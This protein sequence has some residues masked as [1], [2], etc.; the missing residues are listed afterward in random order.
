M[1]C[2]FMLRLGMRK[3]QLVVIRIY[4]VKDTLCV[5]DFQRGHCALFVCCV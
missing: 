1:C 5:L 3:P 4:C 2:S